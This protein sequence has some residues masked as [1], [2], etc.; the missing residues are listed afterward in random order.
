MTKDTHSWL[1]YYRAYSETDEFKEKL[2]HTINQIKQ[3]PEDSKGIVFF[4][5]GKDST[6]ALDL[7][8][9]YYKGEK[10]VW[11]HDWVYTMPRKFQNEIQQNM[12]KIIDIEDWETYF[13]RQYKKTNDKGQLEGLDPVMFKCLN[14][15][16]KE[17]NADYTFSGMRAAE[18]STRERFTNNA[19]KQSGA[20]QLFPVKNFETKDVWAY[21]CKNELPFHSWYDRPKKRLSVLLSEGYAS[22]Y[23]GSEDLWNKDVWKLLDE[24]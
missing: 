18:S 21:I 23:G 12:K 8:K 15:A 22:T 17:T 24:R 1:K 9:K 6:C 11:N 19:R 16:I 20:Y 5:G 2:E 13:T 4:S 10:A 14:E 7:V 3:I